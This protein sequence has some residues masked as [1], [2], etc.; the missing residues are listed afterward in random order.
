M[1]KL[2]QRLPA[3]PASSATGHTI[4]DKHEDIAVLTGL[5]ESLV[6]SIHKLT[7]N[8]LASPRDCRETIEKA[9]E[10]L[11][12]HEGSCC[13]VIHLLKARL[14]FF[15]LPQSTAMVNKSSLEGPVF[16]LKSNDVQTR[17]LTVDEIL[18]D[19]ENAFGCVRASAGLYP[20][21]EIVTFALSV[22]VYRLMVALRAVDSVVQASKESGPGLLELGSKGPELLRNFGGVGDQLDMWLGRYER[23]SPLRAETL[24]SHVPLDNDEQPLYRTYLST[25]LL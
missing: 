2:E 4:S 7:S 10:L 5:P 3:A 1:K 13:Y 14:R 8:S 17:L 11:Q 16:L 19:L 24:F 22:V 6:R 15:S 18:I 21:I 25:P 9:E 20:C 23:R 12:V